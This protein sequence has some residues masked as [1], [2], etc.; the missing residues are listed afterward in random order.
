MFKNLLYQ[1]KQCSFYKALRRRLFSNYCR[2]MSFHHAFWMVLGR[3]HQVHRP[4]A[5]ALNF[6]HLCVLRSKN[7]LVGMSTWTRWWGI[8]PQKYC[9]M[10]SRGVSVW[11]ET[12]SWD[13]AVWCIWIPDIDTDIYDQNKLTEVSLICIFQYSV[14]GLLDASG[15]PKCEVL[16]CRPTPTR[17]PKTSKSKIKLQEWKRKSHGKKNLNAFC[18]CPF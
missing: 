8:A 7:R 14:R 6:K 12:L 17:I 4:Q 13:H 18:P 5:F 1:F 15:V 2:F 16:S 11:P 9:A 10:P 3:T